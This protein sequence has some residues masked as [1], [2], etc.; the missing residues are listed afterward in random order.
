MVCIGD[1]DQNLAVYEELLK[2]L[3]D[4]VITVRHVFVF[5]GLLARMFD[6][7]SLDST[8]TLRVYQV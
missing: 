5:K 3:T 8:S 1:E 2:K 7:L 6:F 4:K